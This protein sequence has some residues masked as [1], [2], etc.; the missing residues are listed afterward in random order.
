MK[1]LWE[2][3]QKKENSMQFD[4]FY[5]KSKHRFLCQCIKDTSKKE[6]NNVDDLGEKKILK[7]LE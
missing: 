2:E 6:Y 5:Y 4:K 1:D 3:S 7:L